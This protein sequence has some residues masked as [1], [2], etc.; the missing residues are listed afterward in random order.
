MK[1]LIILLVIVATTSMAG[2]TGMQIPLDTKGQAAADIQTEAALMST[3][4]MRSLIERYGRTDVTLAAGYIV[5]C[6][7]LNDPAMMKTLQLQEYS[8]EA[9]EKAYEVLIFGKIDETLKLQHGVFSFKTYEKLVRKQSSKTVANA[10]KHSSPQQVYAS[11]SYLADLERS[12]PVS[13][14][15][16]LSNA[17]LM[18]KIRNRYL[19]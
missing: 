5:E 4:E 10:L 14:R 11:S 13:L 12:M 2:C 1:K 3:L 15:K 16:V 7:S 18:E 9:I 19:G 17:S 8:A 6:I